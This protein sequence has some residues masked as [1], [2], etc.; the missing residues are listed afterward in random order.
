[1]NKTKRTLCVT[2]AVALLMLSGCGGR[3]PETVI[4]EIITYHGCYGAQADEKVGKLLHELKKQDKKQAALWSDIMDYWE[5]ADSEMPVNLKKLPDDLPQDDS[6]CIAVLGYQLNPD[7]TM[8]EELI[9]RLAVAC[10]CAEQYP[11]AYVV[12]TGGGTALNAPEATEADCMGAWLL[13]NGLDAHRLIIENRSRTTAENAENSYVILLRDYPQVDSVVLVSSD[14]HIAWGSVLFEAAF[15][16]SAAERQTPEI[17]VISNCACPI[18]N[19]YFQSDDML[20]WEAGGLMQMIGRDDLAMDFYQ[21][22]AA[23]EKPPL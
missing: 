19:D 1:M 15:L 13:E 5:Y 23:M 10:A 22:Y 4:E 8:Q 17:H 18:A 2:A 6:L 9:A 7:G 16:K 3:A 21:N 20:R 12:C 11:N 14:Y